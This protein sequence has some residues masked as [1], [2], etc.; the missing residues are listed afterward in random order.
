MAFARW[1]ILLIHFGLDWAFTIVLL[2]MQEGVVSDHIGS[3]GLYFPLSQCRTRYLDTMDCMYV[4]H[5]QRWTSQNDQ[6]TDRAS[7]FGVA[8]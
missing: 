3:D 5:D 4:T 8:D 1:K 6:G 2:K 7:V